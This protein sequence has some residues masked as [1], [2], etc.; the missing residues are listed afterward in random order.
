MLLINQY[1][2]FFQVKK[3]FTDSVLDPHFLECYIKD[4]K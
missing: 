1:I 4:F 3:S 2:Y